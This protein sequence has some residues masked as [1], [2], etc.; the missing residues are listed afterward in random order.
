MQQAS[1]PQD[2]LPLTNDDWAL[3][4][5]VA[6]AL[7]THADL[8]DDLVA[9]DPF[10]RLLR[11]WTIFLLL[12]AQEML[13]SIMALVKAGHRR[14][15]YGL[16]RP[17]IEYYIRLR[18]YTLDAAE[19]S[20]PWRASGELGPAGMGLRETM[21]FNDL[22]SGSG[23]LALL[24][25]RLPEL[26]FSGMTDDQQQTFRD[27]LAEAHAYRTQRWEKMLALVESENEDRKNLIDYEYGFTGAY[28][29][30]DQLASF[31]VLFDVHGNGAKPNLE[32]RFSE[33]RIL[34]VAMFYGILLMDA[35]G[36]ASGREYGFH[37]FR[38]RFIEHFPDD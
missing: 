20:G 30:G 8:I 34:G 27:L 3:A 16:I 25:N 9:D 19:R 29:H 5:E 31:D 1:Q 38:G 18:F 14:A 33:R 26:D 32:S 23:K 35:A 4:G 28:L 2:V 22:W 21:A 10:Q 36:S 12:L 37:H 17:L 24:M 6:E 11:T 7:R 15:A 13:D